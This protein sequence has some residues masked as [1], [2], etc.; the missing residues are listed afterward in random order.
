MQKIF[1]HDVFFSL[2][3]SPRERHLYGAPLPPIGRLTYAPIIV[4]DQPDARRDQCDGKRPQP[5][6]FGKKKG[7]Q[8]GK[9]SFT[10][11]S[12]FFVT[13]G[14][15]K[16]YAFCCVC[17]G[18]RSAVGGYPL[19]LPYPL[20]QPTENIRTTQLRC[21]FERP[22]LFIFSDNSAQHCPGIWPFC[23]VRTANTAISSNISYYV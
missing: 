4:A 2:A 6:N 20:G 13:D 15:K 17:S 14:A 23:E 8:K 5:R 19:D 16:D 18:I 22:L 3:F 21:T 10:N 1:C 12:F 7:E 9:S 11:I